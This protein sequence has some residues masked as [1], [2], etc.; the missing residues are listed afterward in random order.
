MGESGYGS[1]RVYSERGNWRVRFHWSGRAHSRSYRRRRDAERVAASLTHGLELI[2]RGALI[3]PLDRD[4]PTF[5]LERADGPRT[6]PEPRRAAVPRLI[7][8][9]VDRYLEQAAPPAKAEST[10]KTEKIQLAHFTAYLAE[11]QLGRAPAL[12]IT[13]PI[14]KD[15]RTWRLGTVGAVTVNKEVATLHGLFGFALDAGIVPANPV[16]GLERLK[17]DEAP[18]FRTLDEIERLLRE[19]VFT[20]DEEK[21]LR[22]ARVLEPHEI[23]EL[24]DL[25]KGKAAYVPVC[26]AAFTG[27]RRGEIVRLTWADV[28]PDAIVLRSRKQSRKETWKRRRVAIHPR[29]LTVLQEHRLKTGGEGYLFLGKKDGT[30]LSEQTLHNNLKRV[31]RGTD[32]SE[33]GWHTLRHSLASNLARAGVDQREIN[34]M[35]GHTSE[36]MARRYRHLFPDQRRQAIERVYAR[37]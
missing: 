21:R 29:L 16:A 8:D 9:V 19:G 5:L 34:E 17:V 27:A 32:L 15:Y 2:R 14:V 26:V 3:V 23:D 12:E 36:A 1:A 20:P 37:G 10:C 13:R 11:V 31:T 7:G 35:L 25:A 24:I 28:E 30:H 4:V 18:E 6:V 33:I 22:Q